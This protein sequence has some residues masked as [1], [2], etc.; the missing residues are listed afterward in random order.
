MGESVCEVAERVLFGRTLADKLAPVA[1]GAVDLPGPAIPLPDR[2]GRPPELAFDRDVPR[3]RVRG[4]RDERDR[5]VLLH[6]LA[7]HELLAAELFALALLRFPDAPPRLRR[8]W[9]ATLAEEQAHLSA[10]LERMGEAGTSLGEVG[11]STHF[12]DVL[13][14]VEDAGA[15]VIGMALVLEQANLDFSGHWRARFEEAGDPRTAETLRQVYEDEIRHV[16]I[17]ARWMR[18]LSQREGES[19]WDTFVRAA[20]PGLGPARARGPVIDVEARRRA[21]LDDDYVRRLRT[22][23]GSRGRVPRVFV[24]NAGVE[25][26]LG[27]R[28][29]SDAVD[30]DLAALPLWS[31]E[32]EDVV[33]APSPSLPWLAALAERGVPVPAFADE[34]PERATE[35]VPWSW[36]PGVPASQARGDDARRVELFSKVW[37][38]RLA[39]RLIEGCTVA[40][41]PRDLGVVCESLGEVEAAVADGGSYVVKAAYSA[42]GRHR[43]RVEGGLDD[44]ARTFVAGAGPVVVERWLDV[45]A[46]LSAHAD[47]EPDRVRHLGIT[48]FGARNG[49]FRGV[50]LGPPDSGLPREV[51]AFLDG[52]GAGRAWDELQR[53]LAAVAEEARDAGHLGPLSIDALVVRGEGGLRLEALSEVNPRQTMGRLSLSVRRRLAPGARGVW[54]FAPITALRREGLDPMG[55]ER[56]LAEALPASLRDGR[57]ARGVLATTDPTAA[58]RVATFAVVAPTYAEVADTL[59]R[60]A[61]ARPG[62][63]ATLDW[64]RPAGRGIIAA[65][66]GDGVGGGARGGA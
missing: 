16:R 28:S 54:W 31:A 6:A 35:I 21:G 55:V 27:G 65:G 66:G 11:V 34:L 62:L 10:Y 1:P 42:S 15:F 33:L 5:G 8:A 53:V 45:V 57:L 12:W 38:A 29:S 17:G 24:M 39:R 22:A 41:D 30:A 51:V 58:R 23:G 40:C 60:F 4:L 9:F 18:R 56:V 20:P 63:R 7:N 46:E 2:P 52:G 19:D 59:E 47:V 61:T 32:R 64:V 48:R 49:V 26:L 13:A 50:V 3:P 44:R 37:S 25:D 14:P 43:V 36:S